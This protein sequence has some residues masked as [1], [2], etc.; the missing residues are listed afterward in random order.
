MFNILK[1]IKE[2]GL[3][4]LKNSI[5]LYWFKGVNNKNFGDIIGPFLVE[6]I[7][8]K[9]VQYVNKNCLTPY[10]LTVGSILYAVNKNAIIW[11]SGIIS[12]DQK[13]K[14]PKKVFSVRGPKTR[15]RLLSLGIDCPEVY[16]DPAL[17]LPKF[18]TPTT[19]KIYELGIIP[20]YVDYEEIKTKF[21]NLNGVKIINLLD[22][23]EKVI[24]DIYS[25]K[26]TMSSS[27]HGIITSH[28]YGS[29]SVW[30][31]F[32]K[33][34]AGDGVKF[35]DYF[36]SVGIKP[37]KPLDYYQKDIEVDKIIELIEREHGQKINIDL[38]KLMNACPFKS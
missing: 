30:V 23:M 10:Y 7:A 24:D 32:S 27:L 37:Y 20:H 33:K 16:G 21:E 4:S 13:V 35:E 2:F 11:G 19:K 15:E 8:R 38:E 3:V 14:K 25:C 5:N 1:K 6:K 17:L 12:A 29:L 36:L 34:L 22:P 18:Y 28:A 9:K 26:R 31:E